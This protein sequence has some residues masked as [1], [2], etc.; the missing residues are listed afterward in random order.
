[1]NLLFR[2]RVND[3]AYCA[4]SRLLFSFGI[5]KKM[6]V[7]NLRTERKPVNLAFF[8]ASCIEFTLV[9]NQSSGSNYMLNN[10]Q[11]FVKF[12]NFSYYLTSQ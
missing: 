11:N 8:A 5:D 10:P 2:E 1:M 9:L 12:L 7:W 6:I 4:P 3:I